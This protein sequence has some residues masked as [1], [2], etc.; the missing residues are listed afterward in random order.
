MYKVDRKG[1]KAGKSKR[2]TI[3]VVSMLALCV[4]IGTIA[5]QLFTYHPNSRAIAALS[6]EA[7][8]TVRESK[9]L[10]VFR[11][12]GEVKQPSIILYPGALVEA[13]CYAAWGSQL[14]ETGHS[15]YIV[16][17]PFNLAVF[18]KNR[19][20]DIIDGHPEESFIIGGHSLGGLMAA[21]YT[22]EHSDKL[23]GM[24]FLASYADS[25]G[26]LSKKG[27]PV[28]QL[29]A[30]KD[31]ILPWSAWRENKVNLPADTAFVSIEGGNHSQFSSFDSQRGDNVPSISEKEQHQ[32]LLAALKTWMNKI[33]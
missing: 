1:S 3:W 11:P 9:G 15:V 30:S 24:F 18:G 6:N 26:D 32:Q 20:D 31:G 19:A 7:K 8:V 10:L 14:A 17:M 22:A 27:L 28:L 23:K 29:T 33:K 5:F 25:K 4:I 2:I 21:R 12:K 16:K 13:S